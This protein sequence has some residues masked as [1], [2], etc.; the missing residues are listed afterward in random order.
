[1]KEGLPIGKPLF[2]SAIFLSSKTIDCFFLAIEML[3]SKQQTVRRKEAS[4]ASAHAR[5]P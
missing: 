2:I 3:S 1:M 4:C 5:E